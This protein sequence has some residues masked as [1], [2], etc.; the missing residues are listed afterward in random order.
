M[1]ARVVA[2]DVL[3]GKL[4]ELEAFFQGDHLDQIRTAAGNR[5]FFM[6][7]EPGANRALL[8]SL[9]ESA[10]AAEASRPIFQAQAA[11]FGKLL[12]GTPPPQQYEV[13][14]HP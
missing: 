13:R 11:E 12:S 8:L 4:D 9:W 10:G 14:I 7:A 5:G 2:L 3:P 6:L 1:H